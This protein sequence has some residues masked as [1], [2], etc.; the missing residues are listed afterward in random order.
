M[1]CRLDS[2]FAYHAIIAVRILHHY[3]LEETASKKTPCRISHWNRCYNSVSCGCAYYRHQRH[4]W[5]T[6]KCAR[7]NSHE[8]RRGKRDTLKLQAQ[9]SATLF[10]VCVQHHQRLGSLQKTKL[11]QRLYFFFIHVNRLTIK[12]LGVR[13][14]SLI[15]QE[16]AFS[17]LYPDDSYKDLAAASTSRRWRYNSVNPLEDAIF[18]QAASIVRA[19][20]F[21]RKVGS[22]AMLQR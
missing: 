6:N 11:I 22:T 3:I 7:F 2:K 14:R 5:F 17:W 16:S 4:T 15:N 12:A 10:L 9:I 18:S 13:P 8:S 21:R 20:P 1:A 19:Y